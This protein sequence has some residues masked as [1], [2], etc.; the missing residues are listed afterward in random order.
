MTLSYRQENAK[1]LA[2]LLGI[3]EEEAAQRLSL[4]IAVTFDSDAEAARELGTH[5][6]E[7]LC[8]TVEYAGPPDDGPFAVEVLI[9][10]YRPATTAPLRVYA[11][12]DG[13]DFVVGRRL[14]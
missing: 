5:I 6:I 3:E 11:G 7:M 2:A 1:T 4:R 10:D 14:R 8:R 9:G 12:E 13:A